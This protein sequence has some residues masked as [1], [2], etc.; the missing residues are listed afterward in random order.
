MGRIS[1]LSKKSKAIGFI[2]LSAFGF[3]MMNVFIKLAG[4]LPVMQKGFFRNLVAMFAACIVLLRQ[5]SGFRWKKGN[6]PLLLLRA[7]FGTLGIFCNFYAVDHL[8]LADA[9]ILNK[10]SPFFAILFSLVLLRERANAVQIGAVLAAFCGALLVIKPGFSAALRPAL[11]GLFGGLCAGLAYTAVRALSKKGEVGARIVFF[12]SAFSTL[13][14]LPA[15]LFDYHPMSFAQFACLI[16]AGLA[17]TLGQF[18]V[19]LAYAHA[20]AKE[21]SVFDYTQVLFAALLGFFIFG[22]T[23]DIWSVIGYLVICGISVVMFFYNR[24][25]ESKEQLDE[26]V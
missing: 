21:I 15:L 10:M 26:R 8:V 14:A 24:T 22:Q 19:T 25:L 17:A 3:A 20:P 18:G 13:V 11:I 1:V 5:K 2:L 12:F 7:S 9:N 16:A 6:L 23:P 4:D